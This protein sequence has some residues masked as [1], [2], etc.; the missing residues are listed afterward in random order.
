MHHSVILTFIHLHPISCDFSNFRRARMQYI[1]VPVMVLVHMW[2]HKR[3][4][5]KISTQATKNTQHQLI[6]TFRTDRK[7]FRYIFSIGKLWL[8]GLRWVYAANYPMN[9]IEVYMSVHNDRQ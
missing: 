7:G 2:L 6:I 1:M 9:L 8:T 5:S 3:G 4:L